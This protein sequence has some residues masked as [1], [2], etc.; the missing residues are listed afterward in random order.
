[1]LPNRPYSKV[2]NSQLLTPDS[3]G[4][5]W[6]NEVCWAGNSLLYG[7][8]LLWALFQLVQSPV[9]RGLEQ[10]Q[11]AHRPPS[12]R[13]QGLAA[14][15]NAIPAAP[16]C[17]ARTEVD[18]LP[19][20]TW[21]FFLTVRFRCSCSCSDCSSPEH[22]ASWSV[23]FPCCCFVFLPHHCVGIRILLCCRRTS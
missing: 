15:T 22:A 7:P 14:T 16:P 19:H 23:G 21:P 9:L 10:G 1:M 3:Y 13:Y 5:I 17:P 4:Q 2:E 11:P 20:S 18:V 12:Q 6:L 8:F